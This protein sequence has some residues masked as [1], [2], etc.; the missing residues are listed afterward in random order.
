MTKLIKFPISNIEHPKETAE[1]YGG[2]GKPMK[3]R[4]G[5]DP[6]FYQAEEDRSMEIRIRLGLQDTLK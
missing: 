5:D 6:D 1:L 3:S 2:N 4:I